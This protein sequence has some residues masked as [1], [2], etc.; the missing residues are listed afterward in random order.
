[1]E[2]IAKIAVFGTGPVG[3][4]LAGKLS[5]LGYQVMVGTRDAQATLARS[6]PDSSGD[7]PFSVWRT[8]YPGIK[9]GSFSEAAAF[10][11]LIVNAT[12]GIGSIEALKSAGEKNLSQK[13]IIDISN[14]LDFSRGMPPS[15]SVCNTDSLG[16]EIQR[17]FPDAKVV[18]TLNT[19]NSS[20]MVA[21]NQLSA[22]NHTLFMS[23]NDEDA[24]STVKSLVESFGW[25]DIIDLGDITTARGTE[26]LLP[27]WIRLWG[28]LGSPLF[29]FKVVR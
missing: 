20:L 14:P 7:P 21:P 5:Q 2:Q 9:L 23:G 25:K 22:G 4:S 17:T 16:E 8:Q 1:M 29:S 3:R 11:S 15:L 27:I 12:A 13:I 24:K 18:K 19:I 6:E 10:G 28:T 26:M